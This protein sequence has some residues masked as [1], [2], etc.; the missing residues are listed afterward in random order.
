VVAGVGFYG[1]VES[2]ASALRNLGLNARSVAYHDL[3]NGWRSVP[4]KLGC[5]AFERFSRSRFLKRL[6]DACADA[7]LL[8]LLRGDLLSPADLRAFRLRHRLPVVLWLIDSVHRVSQGIELARESTMVC[9]YNA[10]ECRLIED[11]TGVRAVFTPLAYDSRFYRPID[12][13][14]KDI[15]LYYVGSFHSDRKAVLD[16][17][18]KGVEG[19]TSSI[20]VD[21]KVYPTWRPLRRLRTRRRYKSLARFASNRVVDHTHINLMTNRARICLNILPD[22]AESALNIRAYEISG[23]GGFQLVNRLPSGVDALEGNEDVV[24]FSGLGD[25]VE[26]VRF[27]L[28]PS[29]IN[30]R[31]RVAAN[32][33]LKARKQLTFEARVR[34]ILE[35]FLDVVGGAAEVQGD[36]V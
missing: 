33:L 1:Y 11:E 8:I 35:C 12:G 9:C 14:S 25:L 5:E 36:Q 16:Q 19:T 30:E 15:D 17:L 10:N 29:G 7:D 3:L 27:Y 22:Q 18:L 26:K 2:I 20:V 28:S 21:G 31:R 23:A 32:A 13:I 34:E 6:G 4:G 24:C